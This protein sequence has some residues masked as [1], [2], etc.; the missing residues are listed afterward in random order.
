LHDARTYWTEAVRD[1]IRED[2]RFD[3]EL[4]LRS[5]GIDPGTNNRLID[6]GKIVDQDNRRLTMIESLAAD[7]KGNVFMHGTWDSLTAEES[8]YQYIW[9]ELTAYYVELGYSEVLKT[10]ND[11]ENH[12]HRTMHR[13]Q[14]FSYVDVSKNKGEELNWE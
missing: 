8:S 7:D 12:K 14:F 5:I 2:I 3:D 11:A 6:H 4:H 13:G 1:Y 10:Y 9:P